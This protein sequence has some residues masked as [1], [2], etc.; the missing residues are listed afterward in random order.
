MFCCLAIGSWFLVLTKISTQFKILSL[1]KY[2]Q[3]ASLF[4][5][6]NRLFDCIWL[7]SATQKAR[8]PNPIMISGQRALDPRADLVGKRY[9]NRIDD[10]KSVWGYQQSIFSTNITLEKFWNCPE[11]FSD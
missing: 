9:E 4:R 8:P 1:E 5:A 6:R 11:K 10:Q 2:H 3:A 7:I